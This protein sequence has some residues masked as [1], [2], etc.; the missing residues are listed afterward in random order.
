MAA[1]VRSRLVQ[2]TN[3]SPLASAQNVR[4]IF[5]YLGDIEEFKVYPELEDR[6]VLAP[7][8]VGYIKFRDPTSCDV[9]L[10]LTN[11]VFLDRA[12]VVVD[13]SGEDIPSEELV[14]DVTVTSNDASSALLPTPTPSVVEVIDDSR[15]MQGDA[16]SAAT[17]DQPPQL[18]LVN[19]VGQAV[20][21]PPPIT[22]NVDPTKI[23][24]IRRTI[25]VGNLNTN[26]TADQV[27]SF[28]HPV[29]E[30][31]YVRMA[32]D[33][34][35]PTRFAFVEFSDQ[36]SV[37][38]ALQYNG[39]MLGD[40]PIK[41]NHSKNA[42]VK[43]QAKHPDAQ[44]RELDETMKKV[45]EAQQ[46]IDTAIEP[47]ATRS[48]S[49]SRSQR[50]QSRSRSRGHGRS[51]SP[52]RRRSRSPFYRRPRYSRSP[53]RRSRSPRKRSR[54]PRRRSRSPRRRSRSPRRRSRSPRRRSRSPRR[55]SRSPRRRSRSPRR[56]SRSPQ[57]YPKRSFSPRRRSRS[58]RRRSRSPRRRSPPKRQSPSPKSVSQSPVRHKTSDS[59]KHS[60]SPDESPLSPKRRSKSTIQHPSLSK[61]PSSPS[62]EVLVSPRR[63]VS[64]EMD[65]QPPKEHV[66]SPPYQQQ[67]PIPSPV[68]QPRTRRSESPPLLK[69]KHTDSSSRSSS[70][71]QE[72]EQS[73]S[74]NE[75]PVTK[76]SPH[77]KHK[78]RSKRES[79]SS[80]KPKKHKKHRHAEREN[81]RSVSPS[82]E[83]K[84]RKSKK[85]RSKHSPAEEKLSS[86]E[87]LSDS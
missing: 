16:V 51:R 48:R 7:S 80:P 3:I 40:R 32:G 31:K 1:T 52:R 13:T 54:S 66:E 21:P 26:I 44:Q 70:K 42:I 18:G 81:S 8:K 6:S 82:T 62:K 64:P 27:M 78:K 47:P 60:R 37:P 65:I 73:P 39:A 71:Y 69:S 12:L 45:L 4:E 72:M 41:V 67:S 46:L 87:G 84:K 30:V 14:V 79:S 17:P 38:L 77:K 2:V 33:E 22:G 76:A 35:Q 75:P 34:T 15:L 83:K 63:S 20:P 85:K 19:L 74:V 50:R 28:F 11:T 24:E 23:E 68:S 9:A 58:P 10:H 43:P 29:G 49:T 55:R 36:A 25:Y 61:Y 86:P 5:S 53:R 59:P 57:F 56:R